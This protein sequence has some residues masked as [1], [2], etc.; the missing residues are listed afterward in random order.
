MMWSTISSVSNF[1]AM[2]FASVLRWGVVTAIF[3]S[4]IGRAMSSRKR[5][6]IDDSPMTAWP[7]WIGFLERVQ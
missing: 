5:S 7:E 1:D 2:Y 6:E 3:P 4:R